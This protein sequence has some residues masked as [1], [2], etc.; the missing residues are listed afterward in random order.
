MTVALSCAKQGKKPACCLQVHIRL[1]MMGNI[2]FRSKVSTTQVVK[3][4]PSAHA[5]KTQLQ[6]VCEHR[7]ARIYV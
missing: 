7:G 1:T 6:E 3:C 2:P 4:N 5:L